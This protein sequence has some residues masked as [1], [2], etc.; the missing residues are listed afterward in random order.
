M[1]KEK[2]QITMD[3]E[4]LNSVDDYCDKF[5][6]NRSWMISQACLQMVN[7]QKLVDAITSI[8]LSIKKCAENGFIDDATRIE[9]QNFETLVSLFSK[10]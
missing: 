2:L 9:L 10:Q 4:L 1:A 8:S 6:M 3:S 7:Q 5:Y